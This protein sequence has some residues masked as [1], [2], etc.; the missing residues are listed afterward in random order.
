MEIFLHVNILLLFEFGLL[1]TDT[2]DIIYKLFMLLLTKMVEK[3][4]ENHSIVV[5]L[6]GYIS[7]INQ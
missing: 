6:D 7:T 5:F 1:V 2:S 4:T 3:T